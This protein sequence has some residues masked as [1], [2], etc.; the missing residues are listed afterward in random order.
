MANQIC[1]PGVFCV[2]TYFIILILLI[3]IAYT[4]RFQSKTKE[5]IKKV[6]V[7]K[8]SDIIN[9]YPQDKRPDLYRQ[10]RDVLE[11]PSKTHLPINV[12][13]RGSELPYQQ[14]GYIYREESDAAYNPDESNR[15]PLYG[16]RDYRGSDIWEYYVIPRGETIKI[17]LSNNRE[18]FSGDNI[19]VKGFAGDWIAE[20]YSNKEY[21]YIPY[22]Y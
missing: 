16:R 4:I 20:I 22:V 15:M 18:I 9:R 17:E 1:I 21:K 13:T 3:V 5:I 14:V 12:R 2:N 8:A 6:Y 11:G 19:S 7:D 10:M